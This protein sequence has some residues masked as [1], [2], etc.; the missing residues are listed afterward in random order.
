LTTTVAVLVIWATCVIISAATAGEV[1]SVAQLASLADELAAPLVDTATAEGLVV[2]LIVNGETVV[3]GYGRRSEK[4]EAKPDGKTLFEI[5]SITKVFTGLLLARAVQR[6]ELDLNAPINDFLPGSI[7]PLSHDGRSITLFDLATHTSRL[8]R[9]PSNFSPADANNPYV[10][11]TVDDLYTFLS[12]YKLR[13]T[14]GAL[15]AYSN[16][17]MGLLGHILS[18]H[19]GVPY[20]TLVRQQI[21]EPLGLS[22]TVI[23]LSDEQRSR[24]AQGHNVDV[25]PVANWDFD[26]LAGAGALRSTANDML[27]FLRANLGEFNTPLRKAIELSHS[28]RREMGPGGGQIAIAWHIQTGSGFLWHNGG[29]GGYRSFAAFHPK[30]HVGVVVLSNTATSMLDALGLE[31]IKLLVGRETQPL[32]LRK[33]IDLAPTILDDYVGQ[34]QLGPGAIFDITRGGKRLMAQLTGQAALTIY[35]EKKDAFYYRAVDAQI[36]FVRDD[37]GTVTSL[38]LHQNGRDQSAK[39]IE[40]DK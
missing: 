21:T 27:R 8:P 7:K 22:D 6:G 23:K 5:G 29:T 3:H 18:R 38:V 13:R 1:R 2:G 28:Q 12:Y 25:Q 9:L 17:G 10:D 32:E 34:Y 31:I 15:Y 30:R 16:L 20:A 4:I 39:R 14:P 24:L 19:T 33:V 37:E 36:S 35:A 11:Y 26:A 40:V